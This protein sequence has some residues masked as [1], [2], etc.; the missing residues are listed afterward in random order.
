MKVLL[1]NPYRTSEENKR[2]YPIE[3]LGLMS[4]VTYI[5]QE[6]KD[7][8]IRIRILD[9]QMEGK[10]VC[11]KTKRGYR[12]GLSDKDL[13]NELKTDRPDLVGISNNYT[14]HTK[15]VLEI[16]RLVK[17]AC[18]KC[19]LALGGAH[20][21]IDHENLI[22]IKEIDAVIRGE[23]EETFKEFVFA[24]Y[25]NKKFNK[26]L[27]LTF[28]KRGRVK[29]NPNRQLL[30]IDSLPIPDRSL[31]P[32]K[33]YLEK[34]NETYFFT[35][36]QPVGTLFTSRG[37]P[38][39]C[40]FCS[41]QKVWGNRWRGRNAENMMKEVEY[42][43]KTYGVKE[44]SFMD[45][46]FMGNKDRIK[47]F[48]K[49]LIKKNLKVSFIVSAG[50]SPSLI[51]DE[52]IELMKKAGFYR[53]CLSIDVGT[54]KA[55]AFVKKPVKLEAMR[56]LVKKSN[57][58]GLWTYA[59]FVI[60]FPFEKKEDIYKTIKFVYDLKLDFVRFY[61]AQPHLGSDLYDIYVKEGRLDKEAVENPHNLYKSIFGTKHL[62][63][64]KLETLRNQAEFGYLKFHMKH[65][66]NPIYLIREFFPKIYS[67]KKLAYFIGLV[68]RYGETKK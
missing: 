4:L 12:S 50:I 28:K 53:I 14:N 47:K 66:L 15:D 21:T 11:I 64:K 29:V 13:M 35:M 52:V 48:C 63:P 54:K 61:I 30:D 34:T 17:K 49:L 24:L 5:N 25:N 37:C 56:E 23:G 44:I 59:T 60:G 32:Y 3:P 7:E 62:S 65:F 67:L 6:I 58:E 68:F 38:F 33:K 10:K 22:K 42:L 45:D 1:I 20:A 18:P 2:D 8:D 31:I 39:R 40:V 55:R 57:S 27:G 43:Y 19:V 41:T 9:T 51:D 16:A 46:Q 36:N 26:I